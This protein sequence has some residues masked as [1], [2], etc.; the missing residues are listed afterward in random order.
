MPP[1]SSRNSTG[2][3]GSEVSMQN[4][5]Y[6]PYQNHIVTY[7]SENV[8]MGKGSDGHFGYPNFPGD[9]NIGGEF[10]L[11]GVRRS[12]QLVNVGTIWTKRSGS[13]HN[14]RY[15]GFMIPSFQA[16]PPLGSS[17][18]GAWSAEAWR[19]MRPD[20]PEMDLS[21]A[22]G[23]L[24]D[25]PRQLK[26]RLSDSPLKNIGSYYL[27]LQFGWKP[28]LNDI[29]K[30]YYL[31][32]NVEKRITQLLRDNGKPVRRRVNL[33][34]NV[35]ELAKL[36]TTGYNIWEPILNTYYYRGDPSSTLTSTTTDRV[37]ASARFRYWLPPGPRDV[38]W[39][40][41]LKR[42]LMGLTPSP[43]TV[44][45]LVPWS[46]LVDYFSNVGDVIEN[47]S[48]GVSDRLAAD[49]F[50]VMREATR[51]QRRQATIKLHDT[52]GNPV[53]FHGSSQVQ[54]FEKSRIKGNPFGVT[55]SEESLTGMQWSILGALGLSK[56]G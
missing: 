46:W 12:A 16:D 5:S 40:S 45:N 21:L 48:A 2:Q 19:K 44:Y 23:E 36:T 51:T 8:T 31:Q 3:I 27:G 49:Y 26:Q 9:R 32:R 53:T 37:W 6:Q 42:E 22:I 1:S 34:S 28:L 25:L 55:A 10:W 50:Y 56:L 39:R 18:P 17:S 20:K 54:R 52:D 47:L 29:V 15:S 7:E 43:S 14:N 4:G 11:Y 35:T 41:S 38:R 13:T 30:L 33:Y 24:K